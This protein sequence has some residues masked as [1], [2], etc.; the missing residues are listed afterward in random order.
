M[1]AVTRH[2]PK[3]S[4]LAAY[5]CSAEAL[6]KKSFPAETLSESLKPINSVEM[7]LQSLDHQNLSIWSSQIEFYRP[8]AVS[9]VS[10]GICGV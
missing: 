10:D 3:A 7:T 1:N 4:R 2:V 6:S 5:V 9:V 8:I